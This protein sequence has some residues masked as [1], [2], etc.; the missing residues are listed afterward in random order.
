MA[1]LDV[2]EV[3]AD[4]TRRKRRLDIAVLQPI[5]LAVGEDAPV[6]AKGGIVEEHGGRGI[7]PAPRVR[8]LQADQTGVGAGAVL[9]ARQGDQP[10]ERR[11]ILL[12]EQQ[13]PRVRAGLGNNRHGFPPEQLGAAS[14]EAGP[15]ADRQLVGGPRERAVAALHRVDREAIAGGALADAERGQGGP[16]LRLEPDPDPE[17]RN[18]RLEGLPGREYRCAH[19]PLQGGHSSLGQVVDNARQTDV[20]PPIGADQGGQ[21]TRPCRINDLA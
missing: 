1:L 4:V 6:V 18:L 10:L 16:N 12:R 20:T 21:L 7:R 17:S 19:T 5:E 2:D 8:Q 11:Q 9:A 3:D 13:L 14:G 15:A